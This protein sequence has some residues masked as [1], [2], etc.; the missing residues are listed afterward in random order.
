MLLLTALNYA[1]T[2]YPSIIGQELYDY[3]LVSTNKKKIYSFILI[4]EGFG[5]LSSMILLFIYSDI[6]L[7]SLKTPLLS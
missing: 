3:C 4:V 2:F 5:L 7:A 6:E 1:F